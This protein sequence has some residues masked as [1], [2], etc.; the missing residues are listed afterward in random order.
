MGRDYGAGLCCNYII[1]RI[2]GMDKFNGVHSAWI[3]N[4]QTQLGTVFINYAR[5]IN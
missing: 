5:T 2:S 3:Q 4:S 1:P